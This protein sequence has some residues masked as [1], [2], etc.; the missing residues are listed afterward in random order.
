VLESLKK[1][2]LDVLE[3]FSQNW[4][5]LKLF[6]LHDRMLAEVQADADRFFQNRGRD[7]LMAVALHIKTTYY[8]ERV[9]SQL[10]HADCKKQS[11]TRYKFDKRETNHLHRS[12][13]PILVSLS[14]VISLT[15]PNK[16]YTYAAL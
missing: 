1:V 4:K 10:E 5:Q 6:L 13:K 9:L 14:R 2:R 11:Y 7:L 3:G 15:R 12:S 8:C 16:A